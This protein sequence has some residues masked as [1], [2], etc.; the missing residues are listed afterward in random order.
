MAMGFWGGI[1]VGRG[2]VGKEEKRSKQASAKSFYAAA[3]E[4]DKGSIQAV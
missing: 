4:K 3:R 2:R 1:G